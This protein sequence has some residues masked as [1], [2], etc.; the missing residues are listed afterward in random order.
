M[1]RHHCRSRGRVR[2]WARE[3]SWC[4][5][6]SSR[7]SIRGHVV[8]IWR[9]ICKN[10]YIV[11][12]PWFVLCSYIVS[13]MVRQRRGKHSLDSSKDHVDRT[14]FSRRRGKESSFKP[15]LFVAAVLGVPLCLLGAYKLWNYRLSA[16]LYTPLNAPLVINKTDM[17]MSRFWGTYRSNLYF[18]LR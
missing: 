16:R 3:F 5:V 14:K 2:A 11:V 7:H 6:L 12:R 15:F 13:K 18:G 4:P 9:M 1:T 8:A 17:D 10:S